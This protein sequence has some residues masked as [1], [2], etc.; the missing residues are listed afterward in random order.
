MA[1]LKIS[2]SA[3]IPAYNAARFLPRCLASV[4]AQTL[5]PEEVIVIDD[6][7]TD[8]T[9]AVAEALGAKVFRQPNSGISSARNAGV[10]NASGEWIAW[11]D[12]DDLWEPEKLERQAACIR[13]ETVLTYTGIRIFD[14]HGTRGEVRAHDPVL[15][16]RMIRY[17]N[18]ISTSTVCVRKDALMQSGGFREDIRASEDWEIWFR[19]RHLGRFECVPDPL[20]NYY[21]HP[22]SLSANPE[23]MI[24]ALDRILDTTLLADLHGMQRWV[25]RRRILAAQLS[26]ASLIARDNHLNSEL[27]F[28]LRSLSAWP[29]PFWMPKRFAMA[30][31]TARNRLRSRSE[32]G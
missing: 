13:A 28:M 24:L 8:D 32:A 10:R 18:P 26:S 1:D 9:A 29:S 11:L 15:A 20:T 27:R 22:G 23:R 7:S 21:L 31:V 3:V 17:Y 30:A 25:W 19:L 5:Q 2:I 6:G 16:A 14:D 12:A 4:F